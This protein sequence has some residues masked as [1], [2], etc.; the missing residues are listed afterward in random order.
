MLRTD[1]VLNTTECSP[2]ESFSAEDVELW[3]VLG[4]PSG[5]TSQVDDHEPV[6]DVRCHRM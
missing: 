1:L 3:A 5:D 6:A 2:F 4:E